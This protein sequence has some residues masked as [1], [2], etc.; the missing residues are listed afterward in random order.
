[1]DAL[2]DHL[3]LQYDRVFE[4][5]ATDPKYVKVELQRGIALRQ[6]GL[7]RAHIDTN[8]AWRLGLNLSESDLDAFERACMRVRSWRWNTGG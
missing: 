5:A 7:A 3:H 6:L 8:K 4:T 1:M 2:V